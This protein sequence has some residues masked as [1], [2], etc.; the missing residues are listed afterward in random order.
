[1]RARLYLLLFLLLQVAVAGN[2]WAQISRGGISGTVTDESG[3]S[4]A[5]AK[6]VALEVDTGVSHQTVS[7]SAGS[8]NFADLPLGNYTVSVEA[9]G[10]EKVRVEHIVVNA[11]QIFDVP[12]KVGV[13]HQDATVIVSADA[14]ALD[15]AST[16]NTATLSPRTVQDLPLNGRDYTQMI[17][18]TPGYTGYSGGQGFNGSL[19]GARRNQINWQIDGVD[20]NDFW[21]NEPAVNEGGVSGLPGTTLPLDTVDTFS[22]QTQSL[23]E[24]G[25]NPAG[26]V[27]LTLRSGTNQFH[28]TAYYFNRNELFGAKSPFTPTK[29][30]V[31]NY[32][33]GVS[34]GA[35]IIK[36]KF[37]FFGSFETQVFELGVSGLA[38]E[39]SLAYQALA[40]A[41]LAKYNVAANSVTSA[42][43]KTFWPANALN[44]PAEN[45]N[46]SSSD[47]ING[48]TYN[49]SVKLDYNLN[50]K[51]SFSFHWFSG[52][53]IQ[54]APSG[55]NLV[56]Y[57]SKVPTRA[58]NYAFIWNYQISPT[59][60]NQVLLG[61]DY[62]YQAYGDEN[63]NFNP[64]ALGF[65]TGVTDIP[66]APNILLGASSQFDQIGPTPPL[67]RNGTTGHATDDFSWTIGPHQLRFG[68][69]FRKG[70]VLENY[71]SNGIGQYIFDGN[72]SAAGQWSDDD[73]LDPNVKILSDFLAG[74][75]AGGTVARGQQARDVYV[76]S[77]GLFVQD[78]WKTSKS[79]LLNYGVRWDYTG[80]LYNSDKNLSI[81]DAAKGGLVFQGAGIGSVYP[82]YYKNFS[83]R[84]G[85]TYQPSTWKNTVIR[86]AVGLYFD[87][88][89]VNI[90]LSQSVKNG[91]AI[92]LQGNPGGS[93]P[94]F[95][96]SVQPQTVV[97]GQLLAPLATTPAATC[98]VNA[99]QVSPCGG[100]SVSQNFRDGTTTNYSL[101]IQQQVTPT[102]ILQLGYVG[103]EARKQ[104]LLRDINQAALNP[105]G[106]AVSAAAKQSSRPL[107][108][109]FP[110]F[111]AINEI[112]SIGNANYNALQAV[113]RTQGWHGLSSMFAYVWSHSLD[114]GTNYRN[115]LPQNSN[116]INA[117]YGNSD[118]DITNTFTSHL[119]YEIPSVKNL[120]H[121]AA[122]GWQVNG[123]VTIH[124]GQPFSIKSSAD[125]SG[126][127][128]GSQRAIRDTSQPLNI[129]LR[130]V[131]G[132]KYWINPN[133]FV[134]APNGT[135]VTS[136][137]NSVRGPGYQDFDVSVFKTGN[138]TERF[139]LQFRAEMFNL[140]NHVNYA[141]FN[142]TV[143]SSLGQLTDTIGDYNGAPGI[144][145]GEP[146]NTQFSMKLIF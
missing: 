125:N 74:N 93:D 132:T 91:G 59:L 75:L 51:N 90:F 27:N 86:G 33:W 87:T 133:A 6:V 52:E 72:H 29:Q 119:S 137:R 118:Y 44:G 111:G 43:L 19:N 123:L 104:V 116:D 71:H 83:P 131:G 64:I 78:A 102:V 10:F 23:P 65:N 30:K 94:V 40:L 145:P 57:Y 1:M 31:R 80:A 67:A 138:I 12:V 38:T 99:G 62:F 42:M 3:A 112:D 117:D 55:S 121:W 127:G 130:T 115:A 120:P 85:F 21:H 50:E 136:G 69:E 106:S 113:F 142:A 34:L 128:E 28:G 84:V 97:S 60:S 135:F 17:A 144:G 46:Y 98:I 143:G 35:P 13:Q 4:V 76:N 82:G 49:G 41:Q 9:T 66:G 15:T 54:A 16:A 68:G 2:G 95:T 124:G 81:F 61:V 108:A 141:P 77:I 89:N 107:Y 18:L 47:P 7:S 122:G 58:Q 79:F 22:V 134:N 139:K 20:N 39:P 73:S 101:N 53:G 36:D 45:G 32:N 96:L 140:F 25:R 109:Q 100:Y 8:Y 56:W 24:A 37:F 63:T 70:H 110:T 92:G 146:F 126:T 88:P 5:A 105:A 11:G 48:H 103:S 26:T 129:G 14:I 114:D